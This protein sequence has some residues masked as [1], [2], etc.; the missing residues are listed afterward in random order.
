MGINR[1][2]LVFYVWATH[3]GFLYRVALPLQPCPYDPARAAMSVWPCPY[4][5]GSTTLAVWP[6]PYGSGR[7]TLSYGTGCAALAV[8]P[9]RTALVVRLQ[10]PYGAGDTALA[11]KFDGKDHAREPHEGGLHGGV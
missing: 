5:P 4:G 10:W 11:M 3:G 6:E 7:A 8:R 1:K 2:T 9:W